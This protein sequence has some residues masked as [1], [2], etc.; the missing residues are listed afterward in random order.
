MAFVTRTQHFVMI[1]SRFRTPVG[2]EMAS[3]ANIR[4]ENMR[5]VFAFSDNIIVTVGTGAYYL[6]MIHRGGRIPSH[7]V[8]A[9]LANNTGI[10][11]R[12]RFTGGGNPIMTTAAV[13]NNAGVIKRRVCP[14]C[15]VMADTTLLRGGNMRG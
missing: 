8:V 6:L 10:N 1:H 14:V 13:I 2:S 11:V 12:R 5:R 4:A 7:F 15:G 9:S 3:L